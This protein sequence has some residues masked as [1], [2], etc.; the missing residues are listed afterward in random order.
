MTYSLARAI[1]RAI[2]E[3]GTEYKLL[4]LAYEKDG[5]KLKKRYENL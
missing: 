5:I 2:S 4:N 3:S 1:K